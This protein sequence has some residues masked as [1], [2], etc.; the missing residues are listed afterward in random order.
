MMKDIASGLIVKNIDHCGIVAGI[1]DRIGLVEII[2]QEIGTDRLEEVSPGIAVKAMI[3]K[4]LGLTRFPSERFFVAN[5]TEHLLG[6]GVCPEHLNDERLGKV[7]DDLYEAGITQL[8]VKIAL[9]VAKKEGLTDRLHLDLTS[10][11]VDEEYISEETCEAEEPVPIHI[12]YGY[13]RESDPYLKQFIVDM[14]CSSDGDIPLYLR[15]GDRNDESDQ[16]IFAQLIKEFKQNW[17]IDS[18]F[19]ADAALYCQE[20]LNQINNLKWLSRVP[21]SLKEVKKLVS[22]K[23]DEDLRESTTKGYR[24]ASVENNYAGIKQRWLIVESEAKKASDLKKL[25]KTLNSRKEKAIKEL[26]GLNSKKFACVPDAEKAAQDFNK[27][28]KS[29]KLNDIEIVYEP[30]SQSGRP[31]KGVNSEGYYYIKAKLEEKKEAIKAEELKTGRFVLA[32]NVLEGEELSDDEILEEYK[33]QQSTERGFRFLQDP[34]FFPDSVFLKTPE[35]I[36]ALAMVM[37]LCLLTYSLG[38]SVLRQ[39]LAKSKKSIKNQLGKPTV[40]PTLRWVFQCFQSI[41]LLMMNEEKQISN[42]TEERR[43]ILQFLG[44]SCEKYY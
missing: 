44:S 24:I 32:T 3:I 9:A 6:E 29:H 35:R 28:L 16:E 12:T 41:H 25:K 10:F 38:Q 36:A 18:L 20:N 2:N 22:Q 1:I 15:V 19:V 43:W 27:K 11:H 17:P 21:A 39:A 13:S 23:N 7:L 14:M 40:T 37:G 33:K 30:Y 26:K 4:G 5:A 8:F 34:I 42:L 31:K